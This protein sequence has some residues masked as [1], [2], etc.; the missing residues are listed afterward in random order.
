[1]NTK[2]MFFQACM[3]AAW[4]AAL[5]ALCQMT[6]GEIVLT[7][8]GRVIGGTALATKADLTELAAKTDLETLASKNDLT[9]LAT[10]EDLAK[11][12]KE[13]VSLKTWGLAIGFI[14][15]LVVPALTAYFIRRR[16]QPAP[17]AKPQAADAFE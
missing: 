11:L 10:K 13:I 9:G 6:T 14:A 1:M 12:E 5:T 7:E 2:T 15:T 4:A 16:E 8:D 3:F 17:S